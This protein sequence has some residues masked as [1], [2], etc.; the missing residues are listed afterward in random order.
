MFNFEEFEFYPW[1]VIT[2]F[3]GGK[4]HKKSHRSSTEGDEATEYTTKKLCRHRLTK[5]KNL[6]QKGVTM[7]N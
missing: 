5:Y 4:W 2:T 3:Y 1:E 6:T 7:V